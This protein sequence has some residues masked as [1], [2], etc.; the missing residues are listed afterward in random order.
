VLFVLRKAM[1]GGVPQYSAAF[2][3][4]LLAADA[5]GQLAFGAAPP[6]WMRVPNGRNADLSDVVVDIPFEV[7]VNGVLDAAGSAVSIADKL[8]EWQRQWLWFLARLMGAG[9]WEPLRIN[10]HLLFERLS[11]DLS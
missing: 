5:D 2:T 9:G 3:G 11:M 4:D 10:L 8:R 1:P 6:Q 7:V